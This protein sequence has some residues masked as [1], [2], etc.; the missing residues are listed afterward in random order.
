[1]AACPS[2]AQSL[3]TSEKT[4]GFFLLFL[5]SEG[6]SSVIMSK[7][8]LHMHLAAVILLTMTTAFPLHHLI[9]PHTLSASPWVHSLHNSKDTLHIVLCS[10]KAVHAAGQ[11]GNSAPLDLFTFCS[12]S[13]KHSFICIHGLNASASSNFCSKVTFWVIPS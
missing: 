5:G 2:C 7:M 3:F 4:L 9:Q 10:V 13:L 12:L 11:L 8:S 1:M 6:I